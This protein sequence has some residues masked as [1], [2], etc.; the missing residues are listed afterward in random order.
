MSIIK[1]KNVD[2]CYCPSTPYEKK[3]LNNISLNVEQGEFLGIVG[4]N[5]SGKSTLAQLFNGLLCPTKGTITVSGKDTSEKQN[6]NELWKK[7]GLVF[8][9]PEKQLFEANVY[10]DVAYGPRN[11]GLNPSE[12]D[13]RTVAAL[14]KVGLDPSEFRNLPPLCLSGGTRRRVAIAGVLALEP[15]VL[16]L[17]EPTAGL[18]APGREMILG[19]IKQMQVEDRITVI[20]ISHNLR[21]IISMADKIA[22]LEKGELA[23]FGTPREVAAQLYLGNFTG[24]IVPDYLRIVYTLAQQGNS[25]R[26]DITGQ[27]EAELELVRLLKEKESERHKDWSIS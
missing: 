17:D 9:Y 3:A 19:L 14:L 6:R 18:D 24:I 15:E 8:Q 26:T 13:K 16:V 25:V 4:A 7:V 27:A 5:G 2:F 12:V 21:E 11:L 20:M 22:V 23:C 1:V 10:D